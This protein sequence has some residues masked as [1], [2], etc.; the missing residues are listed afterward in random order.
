MERAAPDAALLWSA[1]VVDGRFIR[2]LTPGGCPLLRMDGDVAT[3]TVHDVRP[4]QCRRFGCFRKDVTTEAYEDGGPLGCVNL[5]DRIEQSLDAHEAYRA[6]Q[7]RAQPWALKMGWTRDME[8][9]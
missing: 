9:P 5:S 6:L 8:Q 1:H 7:K 2:L 3:C 4:Y